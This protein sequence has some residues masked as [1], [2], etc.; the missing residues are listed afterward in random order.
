MNTISIQRM[1]EDK[2]AFIDNILQNQIN[3]NSPSELNMNN[4]REYS[5]LTD[6]ILTLEN[7][8]ESTNDLKKKKYDEDIQCNDIL[9]CYEI[10]N[11]PEVSSFQFPCCEENNIKFERL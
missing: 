3:D 2:G 5:L 9:N 6:E 1:F 10:I 4:K 11:P 8:G 7:L